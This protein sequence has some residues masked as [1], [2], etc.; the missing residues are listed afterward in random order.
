MST[1]IAI[2]YH[3][4][5]YIMVKRL[6]SNVSV[7]TNKE[8]SIIIII[9]YFFLSCCVST[10]KVRALNQLWCQYMW[11]SKSWFY[12]LKHFVNSGINF[13]DTLTSQTTKYQ[14]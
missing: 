6:L 3:L 14:G 7:Q 8:Y 4:F 10:Q 1:A 13:C 11:N 12:D 2:L 9:I 5:T